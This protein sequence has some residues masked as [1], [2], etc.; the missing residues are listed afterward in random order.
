M[1]IENNNIEA[2]LECFKYLKLICFILQQY[3][4]VTKIDVFDLNIQFRQHL[5]L[6]A[7]KNMYQ[8]IE[9]AQQI[10]KQNVI[11]AICY[12]SDFLRTSF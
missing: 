7:S 3:V 2:I 11:F 10:N 1:C 8:C 9:F 4:C 12:K 6:N 5:N